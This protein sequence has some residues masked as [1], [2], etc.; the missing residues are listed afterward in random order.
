MVFHGHITY[1]SWFSDL[2]YRWYIRM[3]RQLLQASFIRNDCLDNNSCIFSWQSTFLK[4]KWNLEEITK[5]PDLFLFD[6]LCFLY[7]PAN[8]FLHDWWLWRSDASLHLGISL[9]SLLQS[10]LLCFNWFICWSE[11]E[12]DRERLKY[13]GWGVHTSW[14]LKI[15]ARINWASIIGHYCWW[16]YTRYLIESL[17]W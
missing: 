16:G 12:L 7:L 13:S 15:G 6:H 14:N 9:Y 8:P 1:L 5:L 11:K 17:N 3:W 2:V 4:W 10:F